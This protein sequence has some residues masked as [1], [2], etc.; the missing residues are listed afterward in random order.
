MVESSAEKRV[1]I[2]FVMIDGVADY[3]NGEE[4]KT[5]LQKANIPTMDAIAA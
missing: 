5:P 1:G 3:S 2:I 4:Q